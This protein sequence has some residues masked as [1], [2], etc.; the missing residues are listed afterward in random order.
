MKSRR[1]LY[2][3]LSSLTLLAILALAQVFA[4]N[5][6]TTTR[7]IYIPTGANYDTVQN[8]LKRE[9]ILITHASFNV[10]AK[11]ANYPTKVKAGK[12]KITADMSNYRM[13]RMLRAGAQEPVRLVI[14]KLRTKQDFF[15]F[16]AANLEV[17]TAYMHC[18]LH[19]TTFLAAYGLDT[20]TAMCLVVPDTYELYWNTT[21]E[22]V[23]QKIAANYKRYWN[24]ERKQKATAHNL[25]PQQATIIASIVE[26]ETNM[27]AEKGNVASVYINRLRMGMPLQADPTIKFAIGDF[28]IRRV[29]GT[30]LQI[31]S[32]YNTY[33][34]T[35]LPPGPICTPSK[36]TI[37]AVL[38]APDT[39]YLYFCAKEDFSG[40]HSFATNLNE[41]LQ[42][43]RRY[44][45]ALDARGI[46]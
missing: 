27:Q 33:K 26:E 21:A 29:T 28:S 42:N 16:V 14:N 4:D 36:K 45:Q 5:I 2:V 12:Y 34:N 8:I 22:K 1:G 37:D 9:N 10:V 17:K 24:D 3:L 6:A 25:T 35:G 31:A 15:D 44:Q 13:V 30:H 41:H 23:L 18:H 39:K 7:Y 38:N 20:N 43:A 40:Y 19:D 32:P 11:A 46:K